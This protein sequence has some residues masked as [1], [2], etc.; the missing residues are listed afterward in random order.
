MYIYIYIYRIFS[1]F[2]V[3][4]FTLDYFHHGPVLGS[5]IYVSVHGC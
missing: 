4:I 5:E 3:F 1:V 2:S